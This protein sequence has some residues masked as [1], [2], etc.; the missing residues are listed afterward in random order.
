MR[1][2]DWSSDVCSSDLQWCEAMKMTKPIDQMNDAALRML[3]ARVH[4]WQIKPTRSTGYAKAEVTLG[5]VDTDELS[6]TTMAAK[7]VPG[8]YFI[9]ELA[10]APG[11]LG[12][13]H[14]QWAW[15]SGCVA[16]QLS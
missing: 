9:G 3:A 12:A 5:G 10:D 16:G 1:I 11:H 4:D 13:F 14:F 7:A 6:S 8:L 15:A 2:S